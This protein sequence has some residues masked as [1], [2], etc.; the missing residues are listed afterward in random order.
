[1]EM[2]KVKSYVTLFDREPLESLIHKK[3]RSLTCHFNQHEN[4]WNYWH[5]LERGGSMLW[6]AEIVHTHWRHKTERDSQFSTP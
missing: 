3:F 5:Y 4:I 2:A 6:P 1:M